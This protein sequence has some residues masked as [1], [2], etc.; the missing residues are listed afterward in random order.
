[1]IGVGKEITQ[2][3]YVELDKSGHYPFIDQPAT[4]TALIR[5]WVEE[6]HP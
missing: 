2:V 3:K 4:I 5:Q 1:M 6:L